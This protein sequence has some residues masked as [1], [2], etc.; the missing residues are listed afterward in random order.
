[1]GWP[2]GAWHKGDA[3]PQ[4][5][6]QRRN[7]RFDER[8]IL[9]GIEKLHN[10][11]RV[12]MTGVSERDAACEGNGEQGEDGHEEAG[13]IHVRSVAEAAGRALIDK[14]NARIGCA[15]GNG[16][17]SDSSAPQPQHAV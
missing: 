16:V 1:M 3:D 6:S 11:A 5:Q 10:A 7:S 9:V 12:M 14:L 15:N 17:A 2:A 8:L 4:G 13:D